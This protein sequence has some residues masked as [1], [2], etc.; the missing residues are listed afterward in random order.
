MKML[1]III[2]AVVSTAIIMSFVPLLVLSIV[3]KWPAFI[4]II[5]SVAT[6]IEFVIV[7]R[8]LLSVYVS[9]FEKE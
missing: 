1:L 9:N 2:G 3:F 4:I 6:I 7:L 5:L 8:I